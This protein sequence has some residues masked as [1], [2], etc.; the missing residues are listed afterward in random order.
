MECL[1]SGFDIFLK[2][3]TQ[4]SIVNSHTITYKSLSPAENSAQ[5][6]F[7][8]SG[9]SDYYINLNSVRLLLRIKQ[10]KTNGLDL[11]GADSNTVGCVNNLLHSIF[12][13]QSVSLNGKS[14]TLYE[15]NYR[16]KAYLE[17]LLNYGSDASGTHLV[18]NLWYLD[19]TYE[20]KDNNGYSTRLN[21]LVAVRLLKC[22]AGCMPTCSIVIKC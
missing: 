10:V 7:N 16:Y 5:L 20:L 8:C 12:N 3:S 14:V 17:K 9:H 22:M 19:S 21:T 1:K 18:F 6:E 13:S 2:R 15:T 11:N 4:S